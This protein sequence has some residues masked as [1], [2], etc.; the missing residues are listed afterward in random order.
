MS[1][2]KIEDLT[3]RMQVKVNRLIEILK[4]K[5]MEYF[6]ISCTYRSQEE[7]NALFSRGRYALEY[8]NKM[9]VMAGMAKITDNENLKPITWTKNSIHIQREAVDFYINKDGKYCN[10]LKVDIDGDG[11]QDWEEFGLIV[12]ECG[13]EWGGRWSKPKQDIPHVQWKD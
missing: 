10:D 8:V 11:I 9:Y 7:Q 12:E 5:N 3:P 2:R 13:L 1:S 4:E 6:K